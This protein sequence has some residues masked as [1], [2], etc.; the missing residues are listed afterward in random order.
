MNNTFYRL[1]CI[2][3]WIANSTLFLHFNDHF[4]PFDCQIRLVASKKFIGLLHQ[5]TFTP[6]NKQTPQNSI[7]MNTTIIPN[8]SIE[9]AAN[10]LI[11]VSKPYYA[12]QDVKFLNNGKLQATVAVENQVSGET[13]PLSASESGRHAAI[14][15]S[16]ALALYNPLPLKHYYLASHAILNRL[17]QPTH[18]QPSTFDQKVIV[19]AEVIDLDLSAKKGKVATTIYTEAGVAVFSLVVSYHV[20]KKDLFGKLFRKQ[21]QETFLP[22]TANPYTANTPLYDVTLTEN[23]LTA[24]LGVIQAEQ[25]L[26]HFDHYPALPVAILCNAM[27]RLGGLHV[28]R[29]TF[30]NG[31]SYAVRYANLSADSLAFAGQEVILSSSVIGVDSDEFRMLIRASD[32]SGNTISTIELVYDNIQPGT[33]PISSPL[34]WVTQ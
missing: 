2:G 9:T 31:I 12:L 7:E 10:E 23:Q 13:T 15:G 3:C 5:N 19:E 27:I 21:Y 22:K 26:G 8:P 17:N 16:L 18:F 34:P 1:R 32:K 30:N 25:C 29:L 20:F 33:D 4:L 14:L 6:S 24:T 11:C 28:G